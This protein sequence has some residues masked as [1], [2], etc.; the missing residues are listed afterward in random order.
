MSIEHVRAAF[1]RWHAAAAAGSDLLSAVHAACAPSCV[2]HM[3]NGEDG[4]L[5]STEVQTT[6][7][8][9]LMPDLAIE[10][11]DLVCT[12]ERMLVQVAMSGSP[13]LIFRIARGRR[14][15]HAQGAVVAR[16]NDQ[17]EIVELWSYLNPGAMLTFPPRSGPPPLPPPSI[18]PGTEADANAVGWDW[19]RA[20]TA[21]EF[22]A[23]ILAS[24][25]PGCIVHGTNGDIGGVEILEY[26]FWVVQAAFPELAVS[27]E[28]GY[29]TDDRLIAQF[30][31]D[32]TQRGWLG[33]APPSGSRVQS[34]GAIVARV[35]A[36][37]RVVEIWIYLAPG[38]GLIFPRRDR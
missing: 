4:D 27:F 37:R 17:S 20:V 34:R 22:L 6:Q 5:V 33:I 1:E 21:T 15:F 28:A 8:R 7:A 23:H 32:G 14:V 11:E 13:S 9:A 19:Q 3:Q 18:A 36:D 29:V 30:Q 12:E 2:I 16:V 26:H 25:A 10:I 35:G 24:A 38:M 31:F